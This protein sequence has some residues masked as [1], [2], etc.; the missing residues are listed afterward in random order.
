MNILMQKADYVLTDFLWTLMP[1]V[2]DHVR[3]ALSDCKTNHGAWLKVNQMKGQADAPCMMKILA[4]LGKVLMPELSR[5]LV[6]ISILAGTLQR[7]SLMTDAIHMIL[8]HPRCPH[9]QIGSSI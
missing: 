9:N 6:L 4:N 5:V 2:R 1:F 8:K 7:L 3:Y